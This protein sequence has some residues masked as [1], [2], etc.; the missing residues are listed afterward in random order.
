MVR[1]VKPLELA[2]VGVPALIVSVDRGLRWG[3]CCCA[4]GRDD[5]EEGEK[6]AAD[7]I[8]LCIDNSGFSIVLETLDERF[9]SKD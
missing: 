8:G 6:K 3:C 9:R 4:C 7:G 5:E 1:G 2:V